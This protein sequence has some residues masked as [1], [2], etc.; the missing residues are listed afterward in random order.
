MNIILNEDYSLRTTKMSQS[1][2]YD[3]SDINFFI[4]NKFNSY[5]VFAILTNSVGLTEIIPLN[6]IEIVISYKKYKVTYSN[7]IRVDS[8]EMEI[9]I[10]LVDSNSHEVYISSGNR[11]ICNIAVDNYKIARQVAIT[12]ELSLS[13]YELYKKIEQMTEMNID[14]YERIMGEATNDNR[15]IGI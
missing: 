5:N 1:E 3:L 15:T 2:I 9:K 11:L 13:V 8:G 14:I 7:S 10:V 12:N 6:F 4:P